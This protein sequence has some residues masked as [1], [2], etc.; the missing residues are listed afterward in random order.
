[1]QDI[2]RIACVIAFAERN[3]IV[4][5]TIEIST[6]DKCSQADLMFYVYSTLSNIGKQRDDVI[7]FLTVVF[8][9]YFPNK[10]KDYISKKLPGI[11][12]MK[13]RRKKFYKRLIRLDF[14]FGIIWLLSNFGKILILTKD[15]K[16]CHH[17]TSKI[18][19]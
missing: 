10:N 5:P 7:T 17:I 14:L 2:S 3:Q 16:F 12:K 15:M 13:A 9:A 1:M 6:N 4:S 11:D 8:P 18:T 19:R